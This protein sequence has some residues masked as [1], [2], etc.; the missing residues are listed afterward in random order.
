MQEG[1]EKLV[2]VD[3]I[4]GFLDECVRHKRVLSPGQ[5]LDAAQKLNV[6]L[7]DEHERLYDL[8][9]QVATLRLQLLNGQEK[10]NVS[11]VRIRIEASEIYKQSKI[12]KAKIGRIEELIRIAKRQASLKE[13]EWKGY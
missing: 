12:Q 3:S 1:L 7:S 5:W 13:S 8:E 4:I 6:L 2:S 9:H 10:I 11:E